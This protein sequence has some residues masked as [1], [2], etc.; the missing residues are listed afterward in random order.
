GLGRALLRDAL[1]RTINASDIIGVRAILVHTLSDRAR[2]FYE[3][4]G[5]VSSPVNPSTLMV[6]L[7]EAMKELRR[8]R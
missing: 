2:R 1:L 6:T 8:P 7:A 4:H 5:F 3:E